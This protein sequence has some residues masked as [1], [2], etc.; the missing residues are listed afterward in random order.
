MADDEHVADTRM[1]RDAL[2][3]KSGIGTGNGIS[4]GT[5]EAEGAI[6]TV[7]DRPARDQ[8]CA[9]SPVE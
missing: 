3:D 1:A 7:T 2:V 5:E 9:V 6:A 8:E 4:T